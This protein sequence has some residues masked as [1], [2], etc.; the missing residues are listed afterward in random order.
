MKQAEAREKQ[1]ADA[2]VG[3]SKYVDC[4]FIL[5]SA[6]KVKTLWSVADQVL[7]NK[8]CDGMLPLLFEQIFVHCIQ[9]PLLGYTQD[10]SEANCRHKRL[11]R[12]IVQRR[13]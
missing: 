9:L 11:T 5:G 6:A 12:I 4:R 2:M 13:S 3:K 10:I 8:C 7:T 1:K